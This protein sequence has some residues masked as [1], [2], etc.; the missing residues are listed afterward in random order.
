MVYTATAGLKETLHASAWL[1]YRRTL[2]LSR[3]AR[4]AVLHAHTA[5]PVTHVQLPCT[6]QPSSPLG[7]ALPDEQVLLR[8]GVSEGEAAGGCTGSARREECQE[9]QPQA[10][11]HARARA[12][13]SAPAAAQADS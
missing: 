10:Q 4:T 7:P 1:P 12:R 9:V 11:E 5:V 13:A 8:A 2:Q 6:T 3:R